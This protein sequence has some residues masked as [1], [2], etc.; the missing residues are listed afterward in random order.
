MNFRVRTLD[1]Q[2]MVYATGFANLIESIVAKTKMPK[3]SLV[4]KRGYPPK[5]I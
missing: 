5:E 4:I 3:E 1:E 2:F